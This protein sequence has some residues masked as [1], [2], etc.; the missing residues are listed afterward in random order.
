MFCKK[1]IEKFVGSE[2]EDEEYHRSVLNLMIDDYESKDMEGSF[3]RS[4]HGF[5][6]F[7]RYIFILTLFDQS[8]MDTW[9]CK[10]NYKLELLHELRDLND[11]HGEVF[12]SSV[13]DEV[14]DIFYSIRID[15]VEEYEKEYY[16]EEI[17]E[18]CMGYFTND[19][20]GRIVDREEFDSRYDDVKKIWMNDV[21]RFCRETIIKQ[22]D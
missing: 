8:D 19:E 21:E 18:W 3:Y 16:D 4:Y 2:M 7:E 9:M 20:Y 13:Y 22:S 11:Y 15:E 14:T 10:D 6:E 5:E 1:F 12:N 17:G